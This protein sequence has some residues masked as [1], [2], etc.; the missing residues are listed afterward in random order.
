MGFDHPQWEMYTSAKHGVIWGIEGHQED[1]RA[2]TCQSCHLM[3]G[4]LRHVPSTC[5]PKPGDT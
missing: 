4:N 5:A 3:E 1:A 2:P